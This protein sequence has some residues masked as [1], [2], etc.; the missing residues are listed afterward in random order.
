M[1]RYLLLLLLVS[2]F[3]AS[4]QVVNYAKTLPERAFSVGLTPAFFMDNG[5]VGLRSIGVDA[6]QGGAL[7]IGLSGGYGLQYSL[8]LSAK[9]IYVMDGIPYFGVDLQY[10]LY[11][12]RNSYFSMIAGLHHWDNFGVDLTGLFSYSPR[13]HFNLSAGL[14]MDLNYDPEMP[15]KIRTRFWLPVNAGFD[16]NERTF[17]FAEYD[18]PV[19]QWSWGIVAIGA[20]FIF[21]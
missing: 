2:P 21:R 17:L 3:M 15:N 16:V 12:T 20:N 9:F 6:G 7:A 18:L 10:L 11:E 8:D 5:S 19:S 14:D 1:K 13:R 4:G